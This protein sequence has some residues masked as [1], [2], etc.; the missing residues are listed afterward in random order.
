MA[1]L[2]GPA[3]LSNGK[4]RKREINDCDENW[5]FQSMKQAYMESEEK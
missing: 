2:P 5:K 1:I 3:R 4:R